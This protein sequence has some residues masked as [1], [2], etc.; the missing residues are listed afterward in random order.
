MESGHGRGMLRKKLAL[1][2]DNWMG[3]DWKE[4]EGGLMEKIGTI[5]NWIDVERSIGGKMTEF[6]SEEIEGMQKK[7]ET[8]WKM[9]DVS[10]MD[11]GGRVTENNFILWTYWS[12]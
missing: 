5:W 1:G 7:T 2:K 11:E 12:T 9:R 8:E 10:A 6:K 4:G 3:K